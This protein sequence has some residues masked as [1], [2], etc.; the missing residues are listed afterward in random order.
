MIG[1][2]IRIPALPM[3]DSQGRHHRH[4]QVSNMV[5]ISGGLMSSENTKNNTLHSEESGQSLQGVG[6]SRIA[7]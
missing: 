7:S 6:L 1:F 5:I 3:T 2:F 4:F